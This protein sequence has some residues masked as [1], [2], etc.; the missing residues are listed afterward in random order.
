MAATLVVL[1]VLI[2]MIGPLIVRPSPNATIG[3]LY[4]KPAGCGA[5]ILGAD[6][7]GQSV[8]ANLVYGT[9]TSLIVGLIAGVIGTVIGLVVGLIAG[10]RVG[11]ST[12]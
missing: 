12:T 4:D 2:A 1:V 6:N 7:E 9:R 8:V 10:F 5:L 11:W 3:G